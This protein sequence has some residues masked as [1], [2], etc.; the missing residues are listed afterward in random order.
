MEQS[1]GTAQKTPVLSDWL[2]YWVF[3]SYMSGP[4]LDTDDPTK[5]VKGQP[6]AVTASFLLSNYGPL[7]IEV[8]RNAG[9]P[10]I[11]MSWGAVLYIQGPP[12]EVRAQIDA[13]ISKQ[14]RGERN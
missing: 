12:P 5:A 11:F 4:N 7:G 2:G 14:Q 8:S 13:E 1:S 6:E 9:D 10:A 3:I